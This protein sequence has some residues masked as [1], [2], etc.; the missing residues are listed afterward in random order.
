VHAHEECRG[1][2]AS[3]EHSSALPRCEVETETTA[4]RFSDRV[5]DEVSDIAAVPVWVARC[6]AAVPLLEGHELGRAILQPDA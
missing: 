6:G 2:Q 5:P 3:A 4:E 1:D